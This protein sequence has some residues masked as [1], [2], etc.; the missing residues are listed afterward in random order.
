[1]FDFS[2]LIRAILRKKSTDPMSNLKSATIWV[3]ELPHRDVHRA[4]IQIIGALISINEKK[5]TSLRERIR[6]LTY[7]DEKAISLQRTLCH[8]YIAHADD[9]EP[10]EEA[11]YLP[12]ILS[13]W[14]EM[15]AGY[16]Q[17]IRNFAANPSSNKVRLQLP[18]LTARAIY[19]FAMQAK[20]ARLRY[21]APDPAVWRNLHRLYL[22]AEREA[23]QLE[24]VKLYTDDK[25]ETTCAAEYMQAL[26]LHLSNPESLLPRQ[27]ELVDRWLDNWA[28]SIT[29]E[30]EFRPHRQI[31]AVNL[32]DMKPPRKLRRNM[33]GEK[34]RYWGVGLLLV[35]VNKTIEQLKQ[36]ELPARLKLSEECR[37]PAC[38]TLI[39]LMSK[40]WSGAGNARQHDRQPNV[41]R[42]EVA[43]GLDEIILQMRRKG[44]ARNGAVAMPIDVRMDGVSDEHKDPLGAPMPELFEARG[45]EWIMEN[46]SVNGVGVTLS[47]PSQGGLKIGMLLGLKPEAEAK[48][49]I[50]IVRRLSS[51]TPNKVFVGIQNLSQ[52]PIFVELGLD[53]SA[54]QTTARA[55]YLP[56]QRE[57]AIARSLLIDQSSY[58]HGRVVELRAQGKRYEVRLQQTLDQSND[59]CR[60]RFDVVGRG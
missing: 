59:Y 22:F 8:E 4:Q 17:C 15:A 21:Y 50:G 25:A 36:G 55:I 16:Q 41:K 51:T 56:E 5:T 48:F 29:V 37:L 9:A 54:T 14:N 32:T 40:R 19:H 60:V 7:L 45:E 27:I 31:Y 38:L 46:E 34:Y 18:Q 13:F 42:V 43:R 6:V 47:N 26:M 44:G 2:G 52:T 35:N 24:P 57:A 12:T 33:I 23:F 28:K 20:W 1:M 39:E 30:Q 3:Q 49:A 11:G 58:R 53:E 10:G